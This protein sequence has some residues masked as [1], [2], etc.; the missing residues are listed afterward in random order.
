MYFM[1]AKDSL[2][3]YKSLSLH[4]IH[5]QLNPDHSITSTFSTNFIYGQISHVVFNQ[6]VFP[7]KRHVYHFRM[8]VYVAMIRDLINQII[9]LFV[10]MYYPLYTPQTLSPCFISR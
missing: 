7:L 9:K 1:K 4:A 3:I 6:Q 2:E 8:L 10:S 5:S